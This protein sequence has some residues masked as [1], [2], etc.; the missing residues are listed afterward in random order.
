MKAFKNQYLTDI[1]LQK[2]KKNHWKELSVI[3]IAALTKTFTESKIL[4]YL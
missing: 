4:K 3:C 1:L 2:K